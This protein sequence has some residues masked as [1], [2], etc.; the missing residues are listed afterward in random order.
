M[1]LKGWMICYC[2]VMMPWC[3]PWHPVL[4]DSVKIRKKDETCENIRHSFANFEC[5]IKFLTN[6]DI[7][8]K[9]IDGERMYLVKYK[10]VWWI[11]IIKNVS[12]CTSHKKTMELWNCD[13]ILT[14]VYLFSPDDFSVN[15]TFPL[16]LPPNCVDCF[17]AWSIPTWR[18]WVPTFALWFWKRKHSTSGK[19]LFILKTPILYKIKYKGLMRSLL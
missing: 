5:I 12:S 9:L 4:K 8:V 10:L 7:K 17:S 3:D 19:C 6:W 14:L 18:E 16:M 11:H 1:N 2:V 13:E 15:P